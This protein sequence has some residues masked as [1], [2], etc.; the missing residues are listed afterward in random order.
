MLLFIDDYVYSIVEF[1]Q[2]V[3]LKT[4]KVFFDFAG[5]GGG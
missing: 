3:K 4:R 5:L 1:E 2:K